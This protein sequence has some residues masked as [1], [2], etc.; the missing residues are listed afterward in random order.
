VSQSTQLGG[1]YLC[2]VKLSPQKYENYNY[3]QCRISGEI[4]LFTFIDCALPEYAS[5]EVGDRILYPKSCFFQEK[6]DDD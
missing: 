4:V 2:R 3:V 1:L 5:P 6:E